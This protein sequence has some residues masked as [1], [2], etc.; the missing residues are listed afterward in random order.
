MAVLD[1]EQNAVVIRIVY[2]GPPEAGKTTSLRA[3]SAS[4]ARPMTT[5]A[6][7]DGRTLYFDWLEYTGGLFE[8]HQIR[9]QIVTVP[10]QTVLAQR[11][12]ALLESADVVVFV[13][14]STAEAVETTRAY[15]TELRAI[16]KTLPGP[17]VGVIVQ[18]NQ[19]DRVG[20]VE[21]ATLRAALPG[22]G[23]AVLESVATE[24]RGVREAFV[25]AVRLAL[26]RVRE[27]LR[28]RSLPISTPDVQTS[29]DLLQHLQHREGATPK[30]APG[31]DGTN[32]TSRTDR[33][34]RTEPPLTYR[35][36]AASA[37]QATIA[38]ESQQPK[39]ASLTPLPPD[40]HVPSGMIWP[41]VE[42]RVL[43]LEACAEPFMPQQTP[44]GDWTGATSGWRFHSPKQASYADPEL[45]R[46]ALIQW[47]R[48]HANGQRWFSAPRAIA[49]AATGDGTWRL[50][51][52]VRAATSVR[53]AVVRGEASPRALLRSL[54]DAGRLLLA[55]A[56]ALPLAPCRLP[57]TVDTVGSADGVPL[58]VGFLPDPFLARRG[59]AISADDRLTLLRRELSAL[60]S[61][62]LH[63]H[64]PS[65]FPPLRTVARAT[66]TPA[67]IEA[68]EDVLADAGVVAVR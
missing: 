26:D 6:E 30:E 45:G 64:D 55:A 60:A 57:I 9:C 20:A 44:H 59:H 10:G 15:M 63:P 8:G 35:S 7:L 52:I 21:L 46:K 49:L 4:L 66:D 50:W 58:Y 11:R 65:A 17:P 42:G 38:Q 43:L 28:N 13:S 54:L 3:L 48:L 24:G 40:H 14:D 12:R 67:V 5:P 23:I 27:F 29:E 33:T 22:S 32:R 16:L 53:D 56:E 31:I 1:V 39:T 19:R 37:F 18:A 25:F 51:Q 47:A 34:N 68:V 36:S 41:P 61:N 2:D 62:A